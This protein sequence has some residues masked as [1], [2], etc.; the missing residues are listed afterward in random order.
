LTQV[1]LAVCKCRDHGVLW[2]MSA[3]LSLEW[4]FATEAY[5][6]TAQ[7]AILKNFPL[8][9]YLKGRSLDSFRDNFPP[10]SSFHAQTFQQSRTQHSNLPLTTTRIMPSPKIASFLRSR[11]KLK[12]LVSTSLYSI[13]L[14]GWLYIMHISEHAPC[15][16]GILGTLILSMLFL[17]G[18]IPEDLFPVKY[19]TPMYSKI[20]LG[21]PSKH[22]GL[23]AGKMA[24]PSRPLTF[25]PN[26]ARG[27]APSPPINTVDP[28]PRGI[29]PRNDASEMVLKHRRFLCRAVQS[30]VGYHGLKERDVKMGELLLIIMSKRGKSIHRLIPTPRNRCLASNTRCRMALCFQPRIAW[31]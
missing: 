28:L 7:R 14:A 5:T 29:Y 6:Q 16:L 19:A 4:Q 18:T 1:K 23:K 22:L 30:F 13:A 20:E 12:T 31:R 26:M 2:R 8:F 25:P 24:A 3:A 21:T 27:T 15:L 9:S 11:G 10:T 17:S